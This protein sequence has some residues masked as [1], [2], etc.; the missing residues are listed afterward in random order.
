[1]PK[2]CLQHW[3]WRKGNGNGKYPGKYNSYSYPLQF[4]KNVWYLKATI[5]TLSDGVF[6]VYR[7]NTKGNCNIRGN[8]K[9]NYMVKR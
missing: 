3:E 8:Y 4:F 1:M 6:N 5:T 9:G 2:R 7:Y